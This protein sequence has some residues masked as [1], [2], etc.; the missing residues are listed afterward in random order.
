LLPNR[1]VVGTEW[2]EIK[3]TIKI[4]IKIQTKINRVYTQAQIADVLNR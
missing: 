2:R 3:T 4:T 1:S